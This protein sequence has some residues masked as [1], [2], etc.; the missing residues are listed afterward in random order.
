MLRATITRIAATA[1]YLG[2]GLGAF[3]G[4]WL[5]LLAGL[6]AIAVVTFT[7]FS[8]KKYIALQQ[9]LDELSAPATALELLYILQWQELLTL[10]WLWFYLPSYVLTLCIFF[11]LDN[12]AKDIRA[13]AAPET[14]AAAMQQWMWAAN[15]RA[16]LN[17]LGLGIALVYFLDTVDAR[18]Q[19]KALVQGLI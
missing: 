12:I 14:K 6:F 11:A 19:V 18:S 3:P 8:L 10:P 5:W 15:A 9:T 1:R 2:A 17:N 16:V 13:G 7:L 4:I